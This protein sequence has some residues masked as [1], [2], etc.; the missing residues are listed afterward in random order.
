MNNKEFI[1]L[2]R[3]CAWLVYQVFDSTQDSLD[4]L[5]SLFVE[6]QMLKKIDDILDTDADFYYKR[7]DAN[8]F[9][10]DIVN[11]NKMKNPGDVAKS[12]KTLITR[13]LK[14]KLKDD[15]E[16]NTN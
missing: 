10:H 16:S 14:Q 4:E 13:I 6:Y 15:N 9:A 5:N 3:L 11:K 7:L 8:V 1:Y 2:E 12:M